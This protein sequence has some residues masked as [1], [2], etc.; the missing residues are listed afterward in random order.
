[1][2]KSSSNFPDYEN[3]TFCSLKNYFDFDHTSFY[4]GYQSAWKSIR[5]INSIKPVFIIQYVI[6]GEGFLELKGKRYHLKQN[7]I[8]LLPKNIP[9]TYVA[10][11][12]NPFSYYYIGMDGVNI[13]KTLNLCGLNINNPV[14]NYSSTEIF[15]EFEKI[16]KCLKNYSFSDNL[17]AL[18]SFYTL[19]CLMS[20]NNPQ[21]SLS[22][23][24]QDINYI[25]TAILYI[26]NNYNNDIT[27][28]SIAEKLGI[29]RT[30]F[31]W[32]FHKETGISPQNYILRFRIG[33]ACKL[34]NMEV[35]VTQTSSLCGFNSPSNFSTQFKKIVGCTPREFQLRAKDGEKPNYDSSFLLNK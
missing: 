31:S 4:A 34:I 24:K 5:N 11:D 6:S 28:S 27:V 12:K 22:K 16:F 2:N 17:E 26:K 20:K 18:A 23:K 1:M 19:L 14:R 10:D 15:Q 33:Q 35:S 30:Y 13:E 9:V 32:L 25:N 21:N 8:F 7:D 29:G 3:P